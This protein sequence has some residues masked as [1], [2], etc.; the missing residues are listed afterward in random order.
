MY[1]SVKAR[2]INSFDSIYE[3]NA[4]RRTFNIALTLINETYKPISFWIMNCSWQQN[5]IINYP[6]IVYE[7]IDCN[8]NYPIKRTMK[9][10]DSITFNGIVAINERFLNGLQDKNKKLRIR[11]TNFGFV[12]IDSISD[13]SSFLDSIMDRNKQDKII[14]S[15]SLYL[16]DDK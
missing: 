12:Y 16:F 4:T 10:N 8:S 6:S 2:L 7:G 9:P 11:N 5:F 15:N 13:E 1:L 3:N 14:W